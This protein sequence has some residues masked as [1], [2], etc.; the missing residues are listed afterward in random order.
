MVL[1]CGEGVLTLKGIVC[2][3]VVYRVPRRPDDVDYSSMVAPRSFPKP[4][5]HPYARPCRP[6][7]G[8]AL[9]RTYNTANTVSGVLS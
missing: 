6:A 1:L 5:R 4:T 9:A 2:R 3:H 8:R 7:F